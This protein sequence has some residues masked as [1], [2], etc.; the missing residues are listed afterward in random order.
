MIL[1]A[2]GLGADE[3]R[4]AAAED[5]S[6]RTCLARYGSPDF[7]V[8]ASPQDLELVYYR[9]S[10]LVHFHRERDGPSVESELTPL[11]NGILDLLPADLR[12]GT[13]TPPGDP[14]GGCWTTSF[15]DRQCRTCCNA[16]RCVATC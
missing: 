9:A 3:L 12:A 7:V 11:P 13:P 14:V 5:P 8:V 4:R 2:R 10:R 15:P 6:L 16:A 1:N